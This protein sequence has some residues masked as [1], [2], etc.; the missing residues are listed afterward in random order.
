M[1]APSRLLA[2]IVLVVSGI[3]T[4][5]ADQILDAAAHSRAAR[6]IVSSPSAA[7]S[8]TA[9]ADVSLQPVHG[10]LRPESESRRPGHPLTDSPDAARATPVAASNGI[11][12]LAAADDTGAIAAA[13]RP[14]RSQ[15]AVPALAKSPGTPQEAPV[16][17]SWITLL[18]G[19]VV[20]AF[21]ASRRGSDPD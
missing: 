8:V 16:A 20:M 17:A 11:I 6:S 13:Q 10:G 18:C 1:K 15:S 3:G 21:M 4:A 14:A 7:H 19:L 9:V 12:S 2:A 5:Y